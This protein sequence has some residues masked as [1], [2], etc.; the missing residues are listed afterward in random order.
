MSIHDLVLGVEFNV[1]IT[2]RDVLQTQHNKRCVEMEDERL[3]R[4]EERLFREQARLARQREMEMY[5]PQPRFERPSWD[6]GKC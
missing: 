1:F 5:Y 3:V 6:D 4:E 2:A